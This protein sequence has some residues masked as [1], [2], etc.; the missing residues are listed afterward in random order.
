MTRDADPGSWEDEDEDEDD[1]HRYDESEGYGHDEEEEDYQDFLEIE[2]GTGS[3]GSRLT[4]LQYV[5]VIV[6]LIVFALPAV[7]YLL[8]A[9]AQ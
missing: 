8:A 1:E 6:L 4:R 7:L 9:L 2:F 3:G 5:T